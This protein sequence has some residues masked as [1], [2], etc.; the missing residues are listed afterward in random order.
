MDISDYLITPI[1]RLPRYMLLLTEMTKV[2]PTEH[3][4]FVNL[5]TALDNIREVTDYVNASL[6]N[7]DKLKEFTELI[8]QGNLRLLVQERPER[9]FIS[10]ESLTILKVKDPKNKKWGEPEKMVFFLFDDILVCS[11]ELNKKAKDYYM[12]LKELW[13]D[14][15]G[16]LPGRM[17]SVY[18]FIYCRGGWY[19]EALCYFLRYRW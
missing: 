2:T 5:H 13:V 1:Q 7:N 15:Q 18:I 6:K 17:R 10:M 11:A 12:S 4:D 9:K 19:H 8:E 3:P 14:D 16:L